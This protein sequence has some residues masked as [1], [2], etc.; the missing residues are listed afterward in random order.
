MKKETYKIRVYCK[1]CKWEGTQDIDKG[2]RVGILFRRECP[3][4]GCAELESLG[5]SKRMP[6]SDVD[7]IENYEQQKA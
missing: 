2:F 1:N 5:I 3:I 6:L 4:C 7:W